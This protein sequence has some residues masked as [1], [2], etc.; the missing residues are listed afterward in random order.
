MPTFQLVARTEDVDEL[1]HIAQL[2]MSAAEP[3]PL[4]GSGSGGGVVVGGA[5][6]ANS[7]AASQSALGAARL[8]RTRRYH[9]KLYEDSFPG[10][11]AVAYFVRSGLVRNRHQVCVLSCGVVWCSVCCRLTIRRAHRLWRWVSACSTHVCCGT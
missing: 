2:M 8:I 7:L 6:G 1:E 11:L 3:L 4:P 9:L 5:A 10:S